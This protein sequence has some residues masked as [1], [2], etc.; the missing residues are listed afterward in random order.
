MHF[1][2]PDPRPTNGICDVHQKP[3][4]PEPTQMKGITNAWHKTYYGHL[5]IYKFNNICN[6]E[7]NWSNVNNRE[8]ADIY[9]YIYLVVTMC[10]SVTR[11]SIHAK[12]KKPVEYWATCRVRCLSSRPNIIQTSA[13]CQLVRLVWLRHCCTYI[14]RTSKILYIHTY[15]QAQTQT[16]IISL[17]IH[18]NIINASKR[19]NRLSTGRCSYTLLYIVVL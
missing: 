19:K 7:S 15:A 13:T 16:H 11:A 17:L 8:K 2:F 6:Q 14:W 3:S 9:I 4:R 1:S 18:I 5:Y 10:G 12:W